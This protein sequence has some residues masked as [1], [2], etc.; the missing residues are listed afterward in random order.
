MKRIGLALGGGGVR[1]LA[2]VL[3]LEALDDLG[4]KPVIISGTS[5]GAIIGALYASGMSGR[6]IRERVHDH[7]ILKSDA[8]PD[9]F[10]K[11]ADLLK[12]LDAFSLELG[13][14]GLVRADK[15]LN[16]LL[17]EIGRDAFEQLEIPLKVTATDFWRGAEVVFDAG[18]LLPAIQASMAVPGIFAPV[19][20]GEKVLVDGGVV[21]L[22]PY[23][24]LLGQCEL[25]IAVSVAKPRAS[26]RSDPPGVI[27]SILGTFDIM[28]MAAL[29]ERMKH[30]PPD[31][32]IRFEI[33]DVRMFDFNK[34]EE[35]FEQAA[36]VMEALLPTL[37][38]H[39]L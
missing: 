15:F 8:W 5:M 13:R 20:I 31:V 17:G 10:K 30:N 18:E 14:G 16:Y 26:E 24:H 29:G 22:V 9:V 25:S 23:D 33:K 35:V 3:V 27:E 37:A 19:C 1:G 7:V 4:C 34:V 28:Q 21:N 12:W 36:P 2:H 6:T 32:F 38:E 11:R 39:I